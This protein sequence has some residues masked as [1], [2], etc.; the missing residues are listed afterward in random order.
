VQSMQEFAPI[1]T[2][3]E[4]DFMT[5]YYYCPECKSPQKTMRNLLMTTVE[6]KPYCNPTDIICLQCH[7]TI[8]TEYYL[9]ERKVALALAKSTS[10]A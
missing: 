10:R 6:I 5:T 4:A 2:K 1:G 9:D 8:T 3:I 7:N